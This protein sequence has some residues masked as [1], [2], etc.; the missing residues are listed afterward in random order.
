MTATAAVAR[1]KLRDPKNMKMRLD[2]DVPTGLNHV[3]CLS[4][5]SAALHSGLFSY[6]P[7]GTLRP[8]STIDH[9]NFQG[10]FFDCAALHSGRRTMWQYPPVTLCCIE[11]ANLIGLSH[12]EIQRL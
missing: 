4:Q 11:S 1:G 7:S 5:G 8:E 12:L 10:R 3:V 2:S 6:V 9:F